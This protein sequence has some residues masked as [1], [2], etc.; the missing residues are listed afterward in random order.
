MLLLDLKKKDP[1]GNKLKE[2]DI[3]HQ[4]G[5]RIRSLGEEAATYLMGSV[6]ESAYMI[7]TCHGA[8][9]IAQ[10]HGVEAKKLAKHQKG[11]QEIEYGGQKT[12][13]HKAHSWGIPVS[14]TS[15]LE[16]IATSHQKFED[17]SEGKIYE[18][19]KVKGTNHIGIQGHA[20]QGIGKEIMYDVLNTIHG[21][22][23]GKKSKKGEIIQFPQGE[24][25]AEKYA[26]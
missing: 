14:D 8:Q 21:Q 13:I 15:K 4:S 6:H 9:E 5:S 25:Q 1:D 20:E 10:Y 19:F 22:S 18:V 3:I 24:Q 2:Y 26:A 17:K 11:K 7:G 23:K 16:A 12:Y